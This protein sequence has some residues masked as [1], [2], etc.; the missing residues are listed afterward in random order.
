MLMGHFGDNEIL[1]AIN[2]LKNSGGK[3]YNV[4]LV[5]SEFQ[6]PMKLKK[7]KWSPVKKINNREVLLIASGPKAKDYKYAIEKY[8]KLKKPYVIAVNTEVAI[9]KNFIDIFAACN[10]L[11]LI[12]DCDI[13]KTLVLPLAVPSSLIS[14][15]LRY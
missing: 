13:Y 4:D 1:V 2:Q 8:I 11:K 15:D 3:R 9:D 14:D 7:G 10:P 12:S 5:R 6:K